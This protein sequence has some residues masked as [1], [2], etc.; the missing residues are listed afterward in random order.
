MRLHFLWNYLLGIHNR[1]EAVMK[2][3]LMATFVALLIVPGLV[4]ANSYNSTLTLGNGSG[5][6]G[7]IVYLPLSVSGTGG[8]AGGLAFTVKY[9]AEMFEFEGINPDAQHETVG[10]STQNWLCESTPCANPYDPDVMDVNGNAIFFQSNDIA[11]PVDSTLRNLM[12]AGAAAETLPDNATLME[13]GFRIVGTV[14]VETPFDMTLAQT[15]LPQNTDAGY[16]NA[17][18]PIP[19]LVGMP[20]MEPDGNGNFPVE[21]VFFTTLQKGILTISPMGDNVFPLVTTSKT[22]VNA[23][24]LTREN[25]GFIKASDLFNAIPNA[26]GLSKWDADVQSYVSFNALFN[27]FDLKVGEPYFVSVSVADT[28]T[29]PGDIPEGYVFDLKV[30]G[31][32]SVNAISIPP[33]KANLTKAS[34]LFAD[35]P[36]CNGLSKWDSALQSYVS[37]NQFFNN[38]DVRV[39]EAYFVSV[40]APGQ[41]P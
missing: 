17:S 2:K 18:N 21:D 14:G 23:I 9:D 6:T 39:G 8:Q 12:I 31:S 27:N 11:D 37:Y 26:D 13:I 35:I 10:P 7:S 30:T 29:I 15:V 28:F 32:T 1:R 33:N 36:N 25:S 22:N 19:V 40:S 20:A 4:F 41:W 34:E 5:D 16:V 24:V 3:K 38:F